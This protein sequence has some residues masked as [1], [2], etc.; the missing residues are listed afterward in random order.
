MKAEGKPENYPVMR[1][2]RFRHFAL[3]LVRIAV[4]LFLRLDYT[5]LENLPASGPAI[6]ISNHTSMGDMLVIQSPMKPWVCWVAKKELFSKPL[7]RQI[8]TRLG[9]I[10]VDRDKTDLMAAR[11]IFTA[12]R[13][14]QII[15]MFPQG[16]RVRKEQIPFVRPRSGA[17]HFAIKTGS[18]ILPV[19]V[20]GRFKLFGKIRIVYGKPIV[21]GL[22]ARASYST[23]ELHK[24]TVDIMRQ[25]YALIGYDYQ[26]ADEAGE[27]EL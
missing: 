13:G 19:A 18:T 23:E 21:L 11:G 9:C 3:T 5:G 14:K 15:G 25:V 2:R 22:D 8:Y 20:D 16:T 17:L 6:L 24:L 4:R 12:L 10:P 27:A 26:L 7:T 1:Y